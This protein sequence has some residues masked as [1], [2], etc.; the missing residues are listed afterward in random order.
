MSPRVSRLADGLL[1]L[2]SLVSKC[3]ENEFAVGDRVKHPKLTEWGIGQ[4]INISPPILTIYFDIVGEKKLRTDLVVLRHVDGP[5]AESAVLDAK[6]KA[7]R[8]A[9]QKRF[10]D[11]LFYNE[12]KK[13][14]RKQFIE[15]LGAACSNWNWSWSFVNNDEKKIIF[16]AWQDLMKGNRAL[17]F[18]NKWKTRDGRNQSPW[19][20]SRENLRLIEEEG[21]SLHVF[22]MI[23]DP[24]F[25]PEGIGRRK[26]G[27]FLKDI[28]EAELLKSEDDWYAIFAEGA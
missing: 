23:M 21:Y 18:S 19:P 11:P 3:M 6:F 8:A 22:T 17:I 16:G 28:A 1:W 10:N 26:I 14:S 4:V 20:E 27:A 12:G 2:G 9:K 15:S 13:T 7:K 5:D 25:N 24:D